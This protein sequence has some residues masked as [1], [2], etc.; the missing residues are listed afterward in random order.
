MTYGMHMPE[1]IALDWLQR[2]HVPLFLITY[3]LRLIWANGSAAEL[4]ARHELRVNPFGY[5]KSSN[6]GVECKA[7]AVRQQL[8]AAIMQRETWADRS[9]VLTLTEFSSSVQLYELTVRGMALIGCALMMADEGAMDL[10]ERLSQYGLTNTE[11][12]VV[13]M[14]VG[15]ATAIEIARTS[16]SSLLT[17]RTHIKRAYEKMEVNSR[18]KMFARLTGRAYAPSVEHRSA[19]R[20]GRPSDLSALAGV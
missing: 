12:K 11:R 14:L 2:A 18:E 7:D 16:G 17:V 10:S 13:T 4:M 8:Q 15:G 3:D 1:A 6:K 20:V 5:V 19:G 9:T